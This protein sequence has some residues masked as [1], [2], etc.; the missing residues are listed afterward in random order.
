MNETLRSLLRSRRTRAAYRA[1]LAGPD[2]AGHGAKV[3]A[4]LAQFCRPLADARVV[5]P[6]GGVDPLAL[7]M[8]EGRRQVFNRIARL[9]WG[10]GAGL[11]REIARAMHEQESDGDG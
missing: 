6:A 4:D 9:V 10:S 5:A 1:L 11:E 3:L 2:P 7:A 8:A